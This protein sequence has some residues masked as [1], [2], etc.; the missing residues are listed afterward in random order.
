M[1]FE[2]LWSEEEL[3]AIE[4]LNDIFNDWHN[5]RYLV[6]CLYNLQEK[7]DCGGISNEEWL[8]IANGFDEE[9]RFCP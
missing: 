2:T 7:Y 8:V 9:M 1:D 4:E 6:Q 5:D 3:E